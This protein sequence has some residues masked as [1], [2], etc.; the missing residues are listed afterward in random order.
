MKL[1]IIVPAHNEEAFI[2]EAMGRIF[3][4]S[5]S[6][7]REVVVV[8]DGSTDRTN[9]IL[10]DLK[11]KYDFVL[12]KHET[13]RGKG[14]ALRT[15][16]NVAKG[17]LVII[18]DADLE[19]FPSDIPALLEQMENN[20]FIAVYGNRGVRQWP[21]F[22]Y[23]YVLGAKLLTGIF[24]ILYGQDVRD[25]YTCYKLFTRNAVLKMNLESNCFEFEAE[26]SCKFAKMGGKIK[27][28]PIRY[29]PRNKDQGKH[30]GFNDAVLGLFTILKYKFNK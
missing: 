29:I 10:T 11:K 12:I 6:M 16:Y 17:D 7:E 20:D 1:S 3:E 26:V 25:V 21:R 19:Y 30:I 8:D 24:N 22:G 15:G 23:H 9:E 5:I 14:A 13:N 27:N 28:V 2:A 18:Q 4:T